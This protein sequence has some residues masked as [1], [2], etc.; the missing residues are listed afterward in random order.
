MVLIPSDPKPV[1][2]KPEDAYRAIRK[3]CKNNR[4]TLLMRNDDYGKMSAALID[5]LPPVNKATPAE[6]WAIFGEVIYGNLEW[7]YHRSDGKYKIAAYAHA[8]L[9]AAGRGI[10]LID[11][12]KSS[13]KQRSPLWPWLIIAKY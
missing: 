1:G 13:L 3:W 12:E 10:H 7:A 2:I 8:A 5:A 6:I 9:E 4:G 11:A